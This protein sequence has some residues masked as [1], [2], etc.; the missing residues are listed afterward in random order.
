MTANKKM[1]LTDTLKKTCVQSQ[2]IGNA[3]A[4]LNSRLQEDTTQL[5]TMANKMF[6]TLTSAYSNLNQN[7]SA[8][9]K[10]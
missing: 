8:R 5:F 9:A 2:V 10:Y 6:K 4:Q 1:M 7:Q 3:L